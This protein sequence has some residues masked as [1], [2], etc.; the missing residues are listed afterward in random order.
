[1]DLLTPESSKPKLSAHKGKR[2]EVLQ[3]TK[4]YKFVP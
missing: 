3:K 2:L 1:M 4:I